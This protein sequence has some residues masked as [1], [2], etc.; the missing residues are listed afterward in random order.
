MKRNVEETAA[1]QHLT[2]DDV[3]HLVGD[4]E[5]STIAA[6][7]A[8]GATYVD[9]EQAVKWLGA[10]TEEPRPNAHGLTPTGE[11]VCDILLQSGAFDANEDRNHTRG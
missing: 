11:L 2:H 7:L 8:T 4:L 9:I 6:I 10:G 5:D 3:A 1:T